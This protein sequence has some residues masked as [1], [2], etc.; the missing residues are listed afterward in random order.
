MSIVVCCGGVAVCRQVVSGRVSM[1][2]PVVQREQ[3]GSAYVLLSLSINIDVYSGS[4]IWF[5]RS[6]VN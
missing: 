5:V 3:P 6:D 2:H 4:E 1:L